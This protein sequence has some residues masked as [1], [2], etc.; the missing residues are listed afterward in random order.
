MNEMRAHTLEHAVERTVLILAKRETVFRFF[1]DSERFASWWGAGSSIDPRPGGAVL[2]RYPNGETASGEVLSISPP[3]EIVFTYGYDAPGKLIPP[4][5]SVVRVQFEARRG[6]TLLT[7]RHE[8][9]SAKAKEAHVA[10]WRFQ[11]ALFSNAVSNELAA[12]LEGVLD[13][14]FSA[15]NGATAG[16]RA[17]ALDASV[18]DD[19]SFRDA[20][21]ALFS[22]TELEQHLALIPVYMPGTTWRRAGAPRQCQ[23]TG[24]VDWVAEGPD[25]AERARGTHVFDLAED[26]RLARVVGLRSTAREDGRNL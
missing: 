12:S 1:T 2:I 11:L 16:D 19:V 13:A 23:G 14:Y 10:G 3:E 24:A 17:K 7:L 18:A 4:G 15:W 8:V 26:G 20:Y 25:G 5:G 9:D 21:A 6:G 22:R